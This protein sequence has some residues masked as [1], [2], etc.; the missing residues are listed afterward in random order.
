MER[1]SIPVSPFAG[2]NDSRRRSK[3]LRRQIEEGRGGREKAAASYGR[4]HK[5]QI[6]RPP[7]RCS[8]VEALSVVIEGVEATVQMTRSCG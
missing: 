8:Q 7:Q 5:S 4:L 2:Y 3:E 6:D 1:R